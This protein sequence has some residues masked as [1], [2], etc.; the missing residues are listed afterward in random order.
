MKPTAQPTSVVVCI[1]CLLL[2]LLVGFAL[3]QKGDVKAMFK[4]PYVSFSVEA[5]DKS[6]HPNHETRGRE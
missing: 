4:A 3:Y 2:C 5:T 1:V 6:P